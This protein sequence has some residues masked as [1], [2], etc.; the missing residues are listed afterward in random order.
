MGRS[1]H[2]PLTLIQ[3]SD[4]G[5]EMEYPRRSFKPELIVLALLLFVVL[6][7][8]FSFFL[9]LSH[10]SSERAGFWFMR[11]H[12]ALGESPD[13]ILRIAD[14]GIQQ[15]IT[16]LVTWREFQ[17]SLLFAIFFVA[18]LTWLTYRLWKVSTTE[19]NPK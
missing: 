13:F 4:G 3:I 10:S 14:Q 8:W 9:F 2:K 19:P 5:K 6:F 11:S 7:A 18:S 1:P 12:L 17:T 16:I 15:P